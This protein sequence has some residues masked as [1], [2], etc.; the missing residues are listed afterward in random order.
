MKMVLYSFVQLSVQVLILMF[1]LQMCTPVHAEAV[2]KKTFNV[3][4]TTGYKP[5]RGALKSL[6]ASQRTAN[7]RQHFCVIGYV[8]DQDASPTPSK[9]AWVYWRE[10]QKLILW[11]AAAQ[12]FESKETLLRSR[13]SLDLVTDVVPTDA[14]IAGST[15]HVSKTWVNALLKDCKD[16]GM[17][18]ALSP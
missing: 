17:S 5:V 12:G 15:Y 4:V 1:V 7:T 8:S 18:Y 3:E 9:M 13:R 6:L 11:V 14:D 16:R 2:Q 10:K